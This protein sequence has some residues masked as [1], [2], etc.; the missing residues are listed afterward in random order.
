MH[1]CL[2]LRL[3]VECRGEIENGKEDRPGPRLHRGRTLGREDGN[4]STGGQQR[5]KLASVTSAGEASGAP[6][7]DS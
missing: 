4:V 6:A 7:G 5:G 1:K 2:R 3:G